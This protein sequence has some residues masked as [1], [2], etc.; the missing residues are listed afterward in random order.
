MKITYHTWI[1]R[2]HKEVVIED[3]SPEMSIYRAMT[4]LA[5]R[6]VEQPVPEVT[7]YGIDGKKAFNVRANEYSDGQQDYIVTPFK[8]E[9]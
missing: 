3:L 1:N 7:I 4:I 8:E 5:E 6:T 2:K 9:A